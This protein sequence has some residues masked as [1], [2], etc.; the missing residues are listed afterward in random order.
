MQ[1]LVA[2]VVAEGVVDLLEPVDVDEDERHRLVGVRLVD[3]VQEGPPVR[4]AGQVVGAGQAVRLRSVPRLPQCQQE[5]PARGH[6]REQRGDVE[7]PL[8]SGRVR[9][10]EHHQRGRRGEEQGGAAVPSPGAGRGRPPRKAGGEDDEGECCGPE[11]VE[12]DGERVGAPGQVHDEGAVRDREE[13]EAGQEERAAGRLPAQSQPDLGDDHQG[14]H[15]VRER[16][17]QR[18]EQG[19]AGPAECH[20]DGRQHH[21]AHQGRG[22]ARDHDR[23]EHRGQRAGHGPAT[24]EQQERGEAD[25]GHQE[26]PL[27]GC[28]EL[29]QVRRAPCVQRRG[30]GDPEDDRQPQ[31]DHGRTLGGRR[32]HD[33]HA[34]LDQEGREEH[35]H[36]HEQDGLLRLTRGGG[37][38]RRD[39]QPDTDHHPG[40][41]R[42]RR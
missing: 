21:D 12:E 10:H 26:Q 17:D 5:P 20:R 7:V 6:Q 37:G 31:G 40:G 39:E 11:Q 35:R 36:R 14:Q 15:Q 38:Q 22:A 8:Q 23:V 2:G 13:Q 19:H 24:V 28:G 41:D 34:Q 3:Q 33:S 4:Q 25:V 29:R 9:G 16:V 42:Q 30:P 32:P 18:D 1:H 27:A